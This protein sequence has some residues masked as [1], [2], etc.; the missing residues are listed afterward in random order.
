MA[1]KKKMASKI[2]AAITGKVDRYYSDRTFMYCYMTSILL[3]V[4]GL[5]AL[6]LGKTTYTMVVTGVTAP[7]SLFAVKRVSEVVRKPA[8][9]NAENKEQ[10]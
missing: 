5:I 2:K 1:A 4:I 3:A 9:V 10:T 8:L 7:L 6:L